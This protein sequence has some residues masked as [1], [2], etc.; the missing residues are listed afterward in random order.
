M[1]RTRARGWHCKVYAYSMSEAD[2]VLHKATCLEN[3]LKT[4]V[5]NGKLPAR[6][7][8]KSEHV[9]NNFS[10]FVADIWHNSEALDPH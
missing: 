10:Y 2:E 5:L 6:I 8:V 7:G 1:C 9:V 3:C 4:I